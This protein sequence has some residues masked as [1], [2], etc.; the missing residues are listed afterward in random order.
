MAVGK[1]SVSARARKYENT[2]SLRSPRII[3]KNAEGIDVPGV[4]TITRMRSSEQLVSWAFNLGKSHPELRSTFQYTDDLAQIGKAAHAIVTASLR[5]EEPDLGDFT[6]NEV[7]AAGPSVTKFNA[8]REQHKVEVLESGDKSYV[9]EQY[10]YGGT[11]DL[12]ARID[13]LITI[14]DFKTGKGIY[15]EMLYQ[16]AAYAHLVEECVGLQVDQTYIL[17]IGR[18]SAEGEGVR[19]RDREDWQLDFEWFRFMREVYRIEKE[20]EFRA[21][22]LESDAEDNIVDLSKLRK[23]GV[24]TPTTA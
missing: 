15:D 3:Y 21:K 13:G 20:R 23:K 14:L 8:W 18:T 5:G 10:Q 11:P 9:S 12:L 2:K 7:A 22:R 4:T 24:L 1:V 19:I 6:P 16:V 17:Q